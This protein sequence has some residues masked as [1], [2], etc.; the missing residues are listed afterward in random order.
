MANLA[1]LPAFAGRGD[2]MI[3]DRLNHA[4]LVDAALLSRATLRR[5]A[6]N[7]LAS[8]ARALEGAS[9]RK[10]VV[11][12]AVFSMDG[13]IA[14]LAGLLD[15][16]ERHDALLI[17]DDAHGFG[18]LGEY[19]RGALSA[20]GIALAA[21]SLHR[22]AGQGGRRGGSFRGRRSGSDRV[23]DADGSHLS[24]HHGFAGGARPCTADQPPR[25][26]VE[27]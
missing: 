3:A 6:H 22:H 20:C 24:L 10:I 16:C 21:H 1:V 5:Y 19:G 7:D 23:A 2:T 12:D 4:S 17:V 27:R 9:G 18:V 13:D 8:A 11:T 26:R 25:D 15:L 14:P